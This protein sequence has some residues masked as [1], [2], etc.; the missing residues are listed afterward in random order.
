VRNLTVRGMSP[1]TRFMP[2]R[3]FPSRPAE[4]STTRVGS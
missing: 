1:R 4:S 3:I 2:V